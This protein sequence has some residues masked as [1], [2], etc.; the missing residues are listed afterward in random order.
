MTGRLP[1][2]PVELLLPRGGSDAD[3]GP[4]PGRLDP[5]RPAEPGG[6]RLPVLLAGAAVVHLWDPMPGQEVLEDELVHADRGRLDVGARV[7]DPEDL[8]QPLDAAVLPTG[9][10]QHREGNVA[11]E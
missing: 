10:V 4:E 7:G 3:A 11:A 6:D 1:D 2:G 5:D 8:Q 9:T